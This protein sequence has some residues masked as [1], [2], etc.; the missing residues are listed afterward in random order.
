M[1]HVDILYFEGCPNHNPAVDMAHDVI[2]DLGIAAEVREI[3][4]RTPEEAETLRFLGSPSIRV[5]DVDIEPSGR[6]R[7]DFGI[8]CRTYD[9][10]GLPPKKMLADA[11]Q[12]GPK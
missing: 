6:E 5:D 2:N 7:G 1:K 4:V 8:S 9:G 3:E 10:A 12:G 11:L